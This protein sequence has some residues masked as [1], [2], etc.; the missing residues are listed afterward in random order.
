MSGPRISVIIP[1]FNRATL[2]PRA[3]DS[4]L[5]Q[6][7]RP[8]EL[9]LVD[10]GS[11]DDTPEVIAGLAGKVIAAG[12]EAVCL[13]QSNAGDAAARNAGLH[14]ATGEWI[15][16]ADDDDTWRAGR[17]TDQMVALSQTGAAACCGLLA[18]GE[19]TK[20]ASAGRLLDGR[21]GSAFLRGEQSAAITSLL[22]HTDSVQAVGDF[23]PTLRVGSD[24]EWIARLAHAAEFC[25]LPRIVAEYN[26]TPVAL[27]RYSGLA[28][29][30][31]RDQYDLRTVDLIRERCQSRSGF[32]PDAWAVFAARTYDRCVKHLLYAGELVRAE[33]LLQA[34]FG[35]GADAALLRSTRRKL[36]KARLLALVGR[37]LQHPKFRN[38]ADVH[39]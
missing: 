19:S 13:R 38:V 4:V 33:Q 15:A 10:D 21:C 22:V 34:G 31:E 30:L 8:L 27:S 7:W 9:V 11:T 29:L 25:N 35:K 2:V 28:E 23:D 14:A 16:F 17:L 3:V 32:D 18:V 12:G 6:D 1:T 37:R 20:P 39:G 24:M 5:A 36:R 26:Q